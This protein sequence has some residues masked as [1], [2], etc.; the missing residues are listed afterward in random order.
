MKY[1][2]RDYKTINKVKEWREEKF[3][4]FFD[5]TLTTKELF[6][7]IYCYVSDGAYSYFTDDDLEIVKDACHFCWSNVCLYRKP[8]SKEKVK[9]FEK[10][11]NKFQLFHYTVII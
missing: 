10:Y 2:L 1:I 5:E 6:E 11:L 4:I 7:K 9:K 8:W 3:K